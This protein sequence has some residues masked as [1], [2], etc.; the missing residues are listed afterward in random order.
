MTTSNNAAQNSHTDAE[1]EL[2]QR[3]L[4]EVHALNRGLLRQLKKAQESAAEAVRAHAKMVN[5]L[6]ETMRENTS[7]SIERD[8]WKAR[9]LKYELSDK[10]DSSDQVIDLTNLLPSISEEELSAIR[11][12]IA[13][14]HHPDTGGSPER[15]KAWNAALDRLCK[16]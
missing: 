11:R 12:A 1:L 6:T 9:A 13:R 7:L 4:S 14:L 16:R 10:P 8:M 3:E 2:L 5:T 15:M